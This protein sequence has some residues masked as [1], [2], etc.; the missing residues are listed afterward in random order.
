MRNSWR[1]NLVFFLLILLAGLVLMRLVY[2]Q[3]VA[4]EKL[5]LMAKN[6][7]WSLLEIPAARGRIL[8]RDGFSLAGNKTTYLIF[9]LPK[10]IKIGINGLAAQLAEIIGEEEE[11]LKERLQRQ[12]LN[13]VPLKHRVSQEI[14]DAVEAKKVEGIGFMEEASRYY[15]EASVAAQLLGF[16]GLD[17]QGKDRGYFGLEGEYDLELRGKNGL[18]GREKDALNRP[19][20]IGQVKEE[21]PKNGRDLLTTL[22]R[23]V[24][25]LIEE[26]L[27][28]GLKRYGAV[29]GSVVV[30]EPQTGEVIGMAA[31]PSY[32]PANYTDFDRN[33]YVN[34][35]VADAYEPGSILKVLIMASALDAG[36]VEAE[37]RC[38][39]CAGPRE[40]GGYT[41][42]TWDKNYY[43]ESTMREVIQHSDN[44]GM[45]FTAEELG[46]DKLLAY[47]KDFGLGKTV[48]IDLQ[49]EASP[50][51]RPDKQ[52]RSIDLA[53]ASF[54]QGIAVT[55]IQMVQAVG[56][57]ANKGK[58]MRPFVVKEVIGEKGINQVKPV[59]VRQVIKPETAEITKEMMINAVDQ[60]EAKW[61]KLGE[62]RIA[63]K[64]GT[65][66]IA[67]AGHYDEKK[68]IASFIGFAPADEPKFVMLVTL[69]E[70]TSSPWGS[71]TA[72]PLWFEIAK[73][74]F[75]YYGSSPQ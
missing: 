52:W 58:M 49:D 13:W 43:P 37:T 60:G 74:L 56:A 51:L 61:A 68:T 41:L 15:P 70:P 19:I 66:Q 64:T 33:L 16:V 63:G 65:A 25:F 57:I 73:E 7:Y 40:I 54:G 31:F 50:Q 45:I 71:E 62:Y 12:D 24:Q 8:A 48:G 11:V 23:G 2:W 44:V 42:E 32:D 22:D 47:L 59:E 5:A 4:G 9:A 20:L 21:K 72:A 75:T 35:V 38:S 55:P 30:M 69:R 28:L 39:R 29:S 10:E 67:V 18:V 53:T 6:Q 27:K 14:K 17:A 34:P 1:F 46:K 36:A 3:L 26:K